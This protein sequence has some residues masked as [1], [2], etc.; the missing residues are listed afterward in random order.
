MIIN[1]EIGTIGISTAA[2]AALAQK[3]ASE[4]F[5][6]RGFG[7]GGKLP[8]GLSLAKTE[9]NVIVGKDEEEKITVE[10]HIAVMNGLNMNQTCLSIIDEVKYKLTQQLGD[11]IGAITVC[12]DELK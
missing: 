3:A 2:I 5:G 4:C 6:V 11:V 1:N 12:V 7:K 10:L 8:F 9:N